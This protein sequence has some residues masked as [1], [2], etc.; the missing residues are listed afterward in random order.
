MNSNRDGTETIDIAM[1]HDAS[2]IHVEHPQAQPAM[3][4]RP[5]FPRRRYIR[6]RL[7]P[8]AEGESSRARPDAP[9]ASGERLTA[10]DAPR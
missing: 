3:G 5:G 8:H 1:E 9:L 7:M 4:L 6:D 10:C 2:T